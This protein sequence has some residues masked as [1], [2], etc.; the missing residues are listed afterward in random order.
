MLHKAY[1][2]KACYTCYNVVHTTIIHRIQSVCG[3][4]V[5]VVHALF[6][7]NCLPGIISGASG[8]SII[9]GMLSVTTD[10]EL[11]NGYIRPDLSTRYGVR[12]LPRLQD[13]VTHFL[14]KGTCLCTCKYI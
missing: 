2:T 9:A 14:R 8:G 1:C 3:V 5:G 12:W 6:R 11:R 13:Q 10:E 7:A 4:P